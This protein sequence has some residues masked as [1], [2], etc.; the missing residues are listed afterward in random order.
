MAPIAGVTRK[1]QG[2]RLGQHP[3]RR[4]V[5]SL[6]IPVRRGGGVFTIEE[7]K[8]GREGEWC[9]S[10]EKPKSNLLSETGSQVKEGRQA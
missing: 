9:V 4:K 5:P 10:T 8:T 6:S 2:R 7:K 1:G 3:D